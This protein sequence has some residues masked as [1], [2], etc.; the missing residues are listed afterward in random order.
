MVEL[1]KKQIA[2]V[3][4]FQA[5]ITTAAGD[6]SVGAKTQLPESEV[7]KLPAHM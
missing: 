3:T 6:R 1:T 2:D 7:A 5:I 4:G